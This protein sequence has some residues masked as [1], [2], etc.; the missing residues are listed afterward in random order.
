MNIEAKT[1]YLKAILITTGF[2][3]FRKNLKSK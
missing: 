1:L 3:H 2:N